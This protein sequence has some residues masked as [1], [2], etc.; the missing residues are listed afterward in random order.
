MELNICWLVDSDPFQVTQSVTLQ[1]VGF[2]SLARST[3][4]AV[5][6]KAADPTSP[7]LV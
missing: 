4:P 2:L 7:W 3:G 5:I 1:L 6:H